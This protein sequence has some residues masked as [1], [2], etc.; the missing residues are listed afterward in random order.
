LS[1][2]GRIERRGR[3]PHLSMQSSTIVRSSGGP[4]AESAKQTND[5][6]QWK[7]GKPHISLFPNSV[8]LQ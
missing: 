3:G 4:T 8:K 6:K 5:H 2:I 1:G 7:A